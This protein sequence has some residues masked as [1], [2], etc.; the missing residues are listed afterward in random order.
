MLGVHG[1]HVDA[2]SEVGWLVWTCAGIRGVR[3][4]V[5]L[6]TA[7]VGFAGTTVREGA[8]WGGAWELDRGKCWLAGRLCSPLGYPDDLWVVLM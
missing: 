7:F 4:A 2:G 3:G 6:P 5:V 8:I 1:E